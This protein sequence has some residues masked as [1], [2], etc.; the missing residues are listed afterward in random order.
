[1]KY[2]S[3]LVLLLLMLIG[4]G[5]FSFTAPSK[6]YAGPLGRKWSKMNHTYTINNFHSDMS[7]FDTRNAI[8]EAFALFSAVTPLTFRE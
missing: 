3:F 8:K 4:S 6:E 7:L 1:M 5:E 2:S